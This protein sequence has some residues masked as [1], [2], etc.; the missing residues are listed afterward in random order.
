MIFL[1][2]AFF[3]CV[4]IVFTLIAKITYSKTYCEISTIGNILLLMK[5]GYC[6]EKKWALQFHNILEE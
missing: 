6:P 2:Y 1:L 5:T 3:K 4:I